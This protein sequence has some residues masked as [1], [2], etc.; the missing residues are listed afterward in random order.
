MSRY[1][2]IIPPIEADFDQVF[3][4]IVEDKRANEQINNKKLEN[5]KKENYGKEDKNGKN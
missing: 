5:N 4:T 3:S 2:K 1:P